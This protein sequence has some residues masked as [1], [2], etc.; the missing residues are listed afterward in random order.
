MLLRIFFFLWFKAKKWLKASKRT[1]SGGFRTYIHAVI[2]E[3][4]YMALKRHLVKWFSNMFSGISSRIYR[5]VCLRR[6][7][8][9]PCGGLARLRRVLCSTPQPHATRLPIHVALTPEP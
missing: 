9:G 3:T 2:A 1:W 8:A 5:N 7:S 6:P 4:M